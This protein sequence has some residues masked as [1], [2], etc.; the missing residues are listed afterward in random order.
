MK[1]YGQKIL[2]HITKWYEGTAY[3]NINF[4]KDNFGGIIFQ[5]N[6]FEVAAY[7]EKEHPDM[8]VVRGDSRPDYKIAI[9]HK[10]PYL[11]IENDV[12][13]LRR[14]LIDEVSQQERHMVENASAMLL[15]SKEHAKYFIKLAKENGL[16]LPY[17]K[18]IHT[19]PLK[20]DIE[21][22][23]PKEKLKGL[24]LVYA[25]GIMPGWRHSYKPYGYRCY[26]GIFEAFIRAGWKVHIY[27]ASY[28]TWRLTE[29]KE[30]GCEIH[31][32][33]P[34]KELIQEMGKYTAGF[35]GYN[36]TGVNEMG[37]KYTQMCMGNKIWDYLAAGIPTIGFQGG[38]GMNIY[39]GKWGIVIKDL[40]EDTI[41]NL[42]EKLEKLKIT[43][44]MREENVMDEDID[45]YKKLIKMVIRD[46]KKKDRKIYYIPEYPI[47]TRDNVRLKNKIRVRNKGA[48]SIYRGGYIFPAGKTSEEMVIN[49]RTFREIKS[50]V[51]LIIEFVE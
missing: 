14:G 25:G 6:F 50:H 20:K 8:M 41:K 32:R 30:I 13:S 39:K 2:Y 49:M 11:L 27:S 18:V 12:N 23:K 46:S 9:K 45:K 22:I 21:G 3:K 38:K 24:N 44:Q 10:I 42:P 48:Q 33:L 7:I 40:K 43:D 15:T 51:S 35:H 29:Y 28:N 47:T 1:I 26:H 19:R 37:Y 17:F 16:R 31:D 5:D 4:M 34:Y 36:Q